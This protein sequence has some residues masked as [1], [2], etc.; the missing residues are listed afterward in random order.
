METE[1]YFSSGFVDDWGVNTRWG[2]Q[3]WDCL[4]RVPYEDPA[5]T[6]RLMANQRA[7]RLTHSWSFSPR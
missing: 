5:P 4:A 1:L 6:R 2:Q 3:T 7:D